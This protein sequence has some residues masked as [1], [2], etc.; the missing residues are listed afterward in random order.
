MMSA[1]IYG[2]TTHAY[3][4]TQTFSLMEADG[5]ASYILC[6]NLKTVLQNYITSLTIQT[7]VCNCIYMLVNKI[8]T[9]VSITQFK[10]QCLIF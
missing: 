4:H 2:S 3:A 1:A 8:R 7:A 10:S 6:L 9:S 5:E